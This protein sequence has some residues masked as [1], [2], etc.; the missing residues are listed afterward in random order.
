MLE[1]FLCLLRKL[2]AK[3][4][5]GL[6]ISFK[7]GARQQKSIEI[8]KGEVF[9]NTHKFKSLFKQWTKP[10]QTKLILPEIKNWFYFPTK[11][12]K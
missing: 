9:L 6:Q 5:I 4:T 7:M 12:R 8:P 11:L 2:I 3:P 1:N 10:N